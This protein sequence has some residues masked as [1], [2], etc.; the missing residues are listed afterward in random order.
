MHT[1]E[2][3]IVA[4][5]QQALRSA[6][7]FYYTEASYVIQR[8]EEVEQDKVELTRMESQCPEPQNHRT[9]ALQLG[10]F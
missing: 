8:L 1:W 7:L 10:Q 9:T 6:L 5:Q 4:T 2:H 3:L